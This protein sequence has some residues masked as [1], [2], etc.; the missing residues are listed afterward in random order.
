MFDTTMSNPLTSHGR[1]AR[2]DGDSALVVI[3][4]LTF[5]HSTYD[6]HADV[7]YLHHGELAAAVASEGTPE[8]HVARLGADGQVIGVTLIN[9]WWLF[10]RDG[11]LEITLPNH[12]EVSA[13]VL[14]ERVRRRMALDALAKLQSELGLTE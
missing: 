2:G 14:D 12:G 10:Q 13:V 6:G 1:I 3:D 11:K 4:S 9:A 7:L 8:G 5:D